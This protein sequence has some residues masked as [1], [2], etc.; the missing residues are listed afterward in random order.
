M[1]TTHKTAG[2]TLIELM[3]VVVIIGILTTISVGSYRRYMIRTNRT[4]ATSA[5]LQLQVAQEKFFLQNNSYA[6]AANIAVAPPTGLGFASTTTQPGGFYTITMTPA[7]PT[8]AYTA[9][10][11]P[12]LGKGQDKDLECTLFSIDQTGKKISTNG[13]IDTASTCWR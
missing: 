6:S 11:T 13:T 2:F 7:T 5:L 4:E 3:V 1:A 12:V 8:T 10:A 9:S